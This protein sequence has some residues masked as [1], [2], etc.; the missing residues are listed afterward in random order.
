MGKAISVSQLGIRQS[1]C[2][3]R[4]DKPRRGTGCIAMT[5]WF[6]PRVVG[7]VSVA[8]LLAAALVACRQENPSPV[9]ATKPVLAA[10]TPAKAQS[11]EPA[12]EFDMRVHDFGLVNEG[13]TLRHVF[14]VRNRG[15]A[16]LLLSDVRTS[17]GCAAATLGVGTLPP[18]GSGPIEV[19]MDTH[20]E[21][22]KGSRSITLS[23]NDP[24]QPTSTLE[25]RYDVER[26]LRLD[27][28]FVKLTTRRETVHLERVWLDGKLVKQARLRVAKVEGGGVVTARAIERRAG[29]Q[30][31]KGLELKLNGKR[32]VS[33]EGTLTLKTGLPNPPEL[34]LPF[35]YEVN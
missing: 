25:I 23:S 17:C 9:P 19:T 29:G 21:R 18:G 1:H 16:P 5:S 27:R 15:T 22:G 7:Y 14:Q 32:P 20:G 30:L 11:G 13:D 26:L 3:I 33:G 28:V 24:R 4:G 8:S 12:I 31:R 35:R 2:L 6:L 10:G 34:S